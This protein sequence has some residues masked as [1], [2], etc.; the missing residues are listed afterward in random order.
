MPALRINSFLLDE[1]LAL[2]I[3]SVLCSGPGGFHFQIFERDSWLYLWCQN[4]K[5]IFEWQNRRVGRGLVGLLPAWCN[6]SDLEHHQQMV[7]LPGLSLQGNLFYCLTALTQFILTFIYLPFSE[8]YAH[9]HNKKVCWIWPKCTVAPLGF[10]LW[11]P[12]DIHMTSYS[13][14][15]TGVSY[16]RP[17]GPIRPTGA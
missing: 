8:K 14:T 12:K 5:I 7:L 16:S 2:M 11:N 3:C 13:H 9:N 15:R 6:I 1:M 10:I 4:S 17:T